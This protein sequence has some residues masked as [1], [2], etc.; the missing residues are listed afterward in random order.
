MEIS[1]D[2][3]LKESENQLILRT[4]DRNRS[5]GLDSIL[6]KPGA[7]SQVTVPRHVTYRTETRAQ[8]AELGFS[9]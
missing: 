7:K 4:L 6:V 8:I 9:G 5:R 1:S 2:N 3:I